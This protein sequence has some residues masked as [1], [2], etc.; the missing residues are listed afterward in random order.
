[1][2]GGEEQFEVRSCPLHVGQSSGRSLCAIV[3]VVLAVATLLFPRSARAMLMPHYDLDS[4]A[5]ESD[6]IVAATKIGERK[7][8]EYTTA[9]TLRVTR[10]Y[11][12]AVA[13]DIEIGKTV[14]LE[15]SLYTFGPPW[16]YDQGQ[17]VHEVA[18]EMIFFLAHPRARAAP[19]VD[20]HAWY[21]VSSGMRI[22]MDGR[23]HRFV[24]MNNPGGFNAVPGERP[25]D[26]KTPFD[27]AGFDVELDR[28]TARAAD[29]R[30]ALAEAASPNR[31]ARL[32]ALARDPRVREGGEDLLGA[33]V[34]L[35]LGKTNDLDALLDARAGAPRVRGFGLDHG[36]AVERLVDAA[37]RATTLDRR[38]AALALLQGMGFELGRKQELGPKLA[39]LLDDPEK[40]IRQAALGLWFTDHMTPKVFSDA[41]VARFGVETDPRLRIA[42]YLRARELG[43]GSELRMEGVEL[44]LVAA[45]AHARDGDDPSLTVEWTD[46]EMPER[47]A[48]TVFVELRDGERLVHREDLFRR[49]TGSSS[50]ADRSSMTF[51]LTFAA[52]VEDREYDLTIELGLQ[53]RGPGDTVER[54]H[55]RIS[56]GATRVA[57][58]SAAIA[59]PSPS[60]ISPP[61]IE[62]ALSARTGGGDPRTFALGALVVV[63][64]VAAM[65]MLERHRRQRGD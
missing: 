57:R 11:W 41:I 62:K 7:V 26:S 36:I 60:P 33:A 45:A 48:E 32:V 34:L 61:K 43:R 12:A 13:N 55:R 23:L 19:G 38:L 24:Q 54:V 5:F 63:A 25:R 47:Q 56:L 46:V 39:K 64:L 17:R 40:G 8:D 2:R 42:L 51:P 53:R 52:P 49:T 31:A 20:P 14:E 50:G 35:A 16:G 28:A 10:V 9:T 15:Y 29:T 21:I 37:G 30:A 3:A 27:R 65:L 1:M 18:P 58:L 22:F 4:L 44:P 6:A 59:A